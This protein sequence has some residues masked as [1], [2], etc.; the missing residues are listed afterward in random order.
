MKCNTIRVFSEIVPGGPESHPG[1][2]IM[3]TLT[4]LG[5]RRISVSNFKSIGRTVPERVGHEHSSGRHSVLLYYVS[6]RF[7]IAHRPVPANPSAFPDDRFPTTTT[8]I[9]TD[10][11]E[12][13]TQT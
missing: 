7:I 4:F 12:K 8:T 3:S 11:L 6:L 5:S 2:F 13:K 10:R 1:T 9:E